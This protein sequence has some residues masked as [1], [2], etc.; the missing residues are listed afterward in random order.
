MSPIEMKLAENYDE[1]YLFN[2][3]FSR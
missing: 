2:I 3:N 1:D